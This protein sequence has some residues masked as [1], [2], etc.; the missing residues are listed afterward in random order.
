[1]EAQDFLNF[2]EEPRTCR[3][4]D[5]KSNAHSDTLAHDVKGIGHLLLKL[6]SEDGKSKKK[7]YGTACLI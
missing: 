2:T 5:F 3:L 6:E 1:M 7:S 4:E